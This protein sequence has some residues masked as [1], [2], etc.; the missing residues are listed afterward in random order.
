MANDAIL[1]QIVDLGKEADKDTREGFAA[2]GKFASGLNAI[3]TRKTQM[4]K[5][6]LD[7][8]NSVS[9]ELGT[10]TGEFV[11][12][13]K[14]ALLD[15]I[16]K[17]VI[18]ERGL[19]GLKFGKTVDMKSLNSFN[20]D[21]ARLAKLSK[22]SRIIDQVYKK[23][24]DL[25]DK[26]KFIPESAK[27]SVMQDITRSLVDQEILENLDTPE[28][29]Q[30]IDSLIK[31]G[32]DINRVMT[33]IMGEVGTRK[34]N[35][36]DGQGGFV[37]T[38]VPSIFDID[39][40]NGELI[41]NQQGAVRFMDAFNKAKEL[42]YSGDFKKTVNQFVQ[43]QDSALKISER[44]RD[45]LDD[46]I[47]RERLKKMRGESDPG[48]QSIEVLSNFI[49]NPNIFDDVGVR[50]QLKGILRSQGID[51]SRNGN[52]VTFKSNQFKKIG[53]VEFDPKGVTYDLS[54]PKDVET[55][56]ALLQ[57]VISDE[58]IKDL[59]NLKIINDSFEFLQGALGD[60]EIMGRAEDQFRED[61]AMEGIEGP[62]KMKGVP[63][64]KESGTF[65]N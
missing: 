37:A 32:S 6:K 1:Q 5:D 4:F 30:N 16:K 65:W 10:L 47:K 60:E 45:P 50:K 15:D 39:E 21:I 57:K 41:F 48:G 34:L 42:G 52:E 26:D 12:Q 58:N 51:F 22:N 63:G 54:D 28:V 24:A 62:N 33:D 35:L 20:D 46:A 56:R 8:I 25:V 11:D 53:D 7:V 44:F 31:G 38:E 40:E 17:S 49:K 3:N 19:G 27:Q 59:D 61:R 23:A 43:N 55:M 18:K 9:K 29:L 13:K 64:G 14:S 36:P 2:F